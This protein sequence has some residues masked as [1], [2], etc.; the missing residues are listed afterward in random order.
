MGFTQLS[1]IPNGF[2]MPDNQYADIIP[3]YIEL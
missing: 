1:V 3:H 2:R